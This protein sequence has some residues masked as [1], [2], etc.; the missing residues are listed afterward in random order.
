M[1]NVELENENFNKYTVKISLINYEQETK[2]KIYNMIRVYIFTIES[3]LK[4][5]CLI[6]LI[7]HTD[8][9]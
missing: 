5:T 1:Y 6:D 3:W 2:F 9:W 8:F 7:I 4:I